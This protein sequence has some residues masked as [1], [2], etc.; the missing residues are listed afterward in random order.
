MVIIFL[1]LINVPCV[2]IYH[3]TKF[4]KDWLNDALVIKITVMN[5]A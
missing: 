4:E 1:Q 3:I 5:L 2:F